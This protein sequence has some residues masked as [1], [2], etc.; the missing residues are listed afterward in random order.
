MSRFE[1][2]KREISAALRC[3]ARMAMGRKRRGLNPRRLTPEQ[4]R[5]SPTILLHGVLHNSTA[6]HGLS[7]DLHAQGVGPL[8]AINYSGLEDGLSELEKT[9][10]TIRSQYSAWGV[11]DVT[12][13]LVGHSMGGIVAAEFMRRSPDKVRRVIT[14]GSRLKPTGA[15]K[16]AYLRSRTAIDHIYA[17]VEHNRSTLPLYNIAAKHDWLVPPDAALAGCATRQTVV[18]G[19]SHLSLL[20]APETTERIASLLN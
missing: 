5:K 2:A 13:N 4:A 6:W 3:G 8:F 10:E 7:D 16:L 14:I 12:V 15:F 9:L 17:W 19:T 11:D 20:Y 1:A 18:A